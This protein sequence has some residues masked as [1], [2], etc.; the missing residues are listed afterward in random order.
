MFLSTGRLHTLLFP[1]LTWRMDS[2][3]VYLTFDD[4]PHPSATPAV[5]DVLESH[6]VPATFFLSGCNIKGNES[7]VRQTA[8][9]GHTLGIHAWS[10][11]RML[12]VSKRRTSDEIRETSRLA[13]DCT[14]V[15]PVWFRPPFG[16]F[17][18]NT[19]AAAREAGCRI[20]MWSVMPGDFK[21]WSD[22]QIIDRTMHGLAPG[23]IIVLHDNPLTAGRIAPLLDAMLRKIKGAGHT[24]APLP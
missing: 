9:A 2:P 10:H 3:H 19:I 7:I 4:G 6:A 12:V 1:S 14:G 15:T 20:A 8:E 22:T 11:T 17:S 13:A 18:W 23:A 16:F 21:P 24:F 5:L